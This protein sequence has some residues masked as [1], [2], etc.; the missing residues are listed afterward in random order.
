VTSENL[1]RGTERMGP[2]TVTR[3]R[4]TFLKKCR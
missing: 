2:Y 3:G 1:G 4:Q